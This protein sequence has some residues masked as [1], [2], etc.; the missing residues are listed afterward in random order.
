MDTDGLQITEHMA[1]HQYIADKWMPSLLGSTPEERAL[2]EQIAG[3]FKDIKYAVIIPCLTGSK[4]KNEIVELAYEKASILSQYLNEK[5]YILGDNL[6]YVDFQIFVG[7]MQ[8]NLMTDK[9]LF[10]MYPSLEDYYHR[11]Q[12]LPNVAPLM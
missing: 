11:I 4:T 3:V 7:L 6:C 8:M 10:E 2:V 12:E 5:K 1:I 9:Q